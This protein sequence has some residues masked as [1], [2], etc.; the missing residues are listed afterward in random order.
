[1]ISPEASISGDEC[2]RLQPGE[3]DMMEGEVP[4]ITITTVG[5]S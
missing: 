2:D 5:C 4:D 3:M 1:M